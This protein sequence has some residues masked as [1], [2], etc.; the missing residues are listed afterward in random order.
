M[1]REYKHSVKTSLTKKLVATIIIAVLSLYIITIFILIN[2]T[3]KELTKTLVS[4][5]QMNAFKGNLTSCAG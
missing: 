3:Q 1:G 4:D 5:L 2:N